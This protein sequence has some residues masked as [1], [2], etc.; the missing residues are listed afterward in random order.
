MEGRKKGGGREARKREGK[1][2]RKG[3]MMGKDREGEVNGWMEGWKT[4]KGSK[5]ESATGGEDVV[6][7]VCDKPH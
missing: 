7:S 3:R 5:S 4:R 6:W 2:E 1:E